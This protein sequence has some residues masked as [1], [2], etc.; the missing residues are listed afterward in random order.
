[1][2]DV[3]G[4]SGSATAVVTIANVLPSLTDPPDQSTNAGTAKSF[5]LGSFADAGADAPWT[6]VIDWG[7]NSPSSQVNVANSGALPTT[8]HT[9]AQPGTY[10]VIITISDD[11]GSGT[12][13]FQ[14][15][16]NPL[17]AGA[18]AVT[19]PAEQT[20]TAGVDQPFTLG[21]FTDPGSSGPWQVSVNWGDGS[22]AT[23]FS[24][25]SAGDLGSKSHT[26][27]A[28]GVYDALVTVSDGALAASATFRVS[29]SAGSSDAGSVAGL[30]FADSNANGTQEADEPGVAGAQLTLQ[31]VGQASAAGAALTVSASSDGN[32][33]YRF[34]NVLPGSYT[35]T[36]TPPAGYSTLGASEAAV[37]IQTG[38]T[39]TAPHF[40]LQPVAGGNVT[41][42]VFA[43]ANANGSQEPDESGV[44]GVELTLQSVGQVSVSGVALTVTATSDASGRYRF[45]NVPPGSYTLRLTPPAGYAAVGAS[46]VAVS[47]QT[48]Q[49][50][51]AANFTLQLNGGADGSTLHLPAVERP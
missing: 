1:V 31:S 19:A 36:L 35:L 32:G 22:A 7:D 29:V 16:V 26:Y 33:R 3:F 34:D 25:S 45:D 28:A 51:T 14:V 24:A 46:E 40:T 6:V 49:T 50:T 18:P 43:D 23:L 30:V 10:N 47:V 38:Q 42:M 20:A 8:P 2:T 48:G 12:G 13:G 15:L 5:T 39:T 4:L 27:A 44:A 21:S 17:P 41:G 11:G 9:Y 37:T